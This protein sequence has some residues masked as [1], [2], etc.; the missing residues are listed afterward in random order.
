LTC[1]IISLVSPFDFG[2]EIASAVERP[3][4]SF[5]AVRR[6]INSEPLD[7]VVGVKVARPTVA[8]GQACV[9]PAWRLPSS[10]VVRKWAPCPEAMASCSLADRY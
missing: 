3:L 4:N 9:S 5:E 2:W 7:Y 6:Q 8:D 1:S 10:Q